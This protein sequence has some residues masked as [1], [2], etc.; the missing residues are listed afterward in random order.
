RGAGDA[1]SCPARNP[2]G[3]GKHRHGQFPA[4]SQIR[5]VLRLQRLSEGNLL[6]YHHRARFVLR[7]YWA[8]VAG[9]L[10]GQVTLIVLS[11]TMDSH[12]PRFTLSK[13]REIWSFS[14]WTF[15]RSI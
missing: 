12:R 6:R 13:V 7:N 2:R 3:I 8:L 4:R 10:S 15:L 1:V 9:M 5:Q 11:Y 14:I